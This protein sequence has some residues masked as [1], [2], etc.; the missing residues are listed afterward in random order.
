MCSPDPSYYIP[1]SQADSLASEA[2]RETVASGNL[3]PSS[4]RPHALSIQKCQHLE[5]ILEQDRV[6]FAAAILQEVV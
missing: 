4:N 5:A 1:L 6:T 3:P 2:S